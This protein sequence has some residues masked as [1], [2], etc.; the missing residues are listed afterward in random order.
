A[1]GTAYADM[2]DTFTT[3]GGMSHSQLIEGLQ[4]GQSYAYH[5]RCS[6]ADGNFNTDDLV[7]S[8]S[9]GTGDDADVDMDGKV[10]ITELIAHIGRWKRGEVDMLRLMTAIGRW[11]RG[12]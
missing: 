5:A 8:F 1:S 9:I 11:F 2:A 12:E 7:I 6:D 4:D 10:D 3:T